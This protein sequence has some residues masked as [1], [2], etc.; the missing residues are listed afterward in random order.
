MLI[1]H[2]ARS[3]ADM[4]FFEFRRQLE[5]KAAMRGA[6]VVVADRFFASSKTCSDCGH[7]LDELPLR[8]AA[9]Y[10]GAFDARTSAGGGCERG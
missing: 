3:V 7:K 6:Q 4:G 2:L 5:Y 8:T 10:R 1:A 9:R